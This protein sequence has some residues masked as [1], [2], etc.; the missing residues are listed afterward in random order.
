MHFLC[1]FH[2]L[3]F[4][5]PCC[6]RMMMAQD[7]VAF[8]M[9]DISRSGNGYQIPLWHAPLK[10]FKIYLLMMEPPRPFNWHFQHH[11]LMLKHWLTSFA[12][13]APILQSF[14]VDPIKKCDQMP[15]SH[16]MTLVISHLPRENLLSAIGQCWTRYRLLS[17]YED[18]SSASLKYYDRGIVP[19]LG[20]R[21]CRF[22]QC[23]AETSATQNELCSPTY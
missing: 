16:F 2:V 17:S 23:T 8:V 9:L 1:I 11:Q 15:H 18:L 7:Q 13:R 14:W 6:L 19:S 22:C 3:F 20:Y 4:L 12:S 21:Y 5:S 10:C